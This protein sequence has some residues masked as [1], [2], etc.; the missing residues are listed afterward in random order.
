MTI[1]ACSAVH[2]VGLQILPFL[3]D[4]YLRQSD[5][6]VLAVSGAYYFAEPSQMVTLD[7]TRSIPRGD[8]EIVKYEWKL[9]DGW[10]ISSPKVTLAYDKPGSYSEELSVATK[11]GA[12]DKD[13]AQVKVYD[14]SVGQKIAFG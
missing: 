12:V 7:A 6:P 2:T 9:S 4:A 3:V 13:Y 14:P 5:D 1:L 8:D 11:S 10:T